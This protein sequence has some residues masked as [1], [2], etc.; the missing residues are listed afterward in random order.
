[1]EDP[2]EDESVPAEKLEVGFT[3]RAPDGEEDV[4]EPP[5]ESVTFAQ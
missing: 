5:T 3:A 4:A 1:M 2:A